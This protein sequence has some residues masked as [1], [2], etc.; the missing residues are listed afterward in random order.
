MARLH[1][2]LATFLR[3]RPQPEIIPDHERNRS[4][5]NPDYHEPAVALLFA[6]LL[7]FLGSAFGVLGGDLW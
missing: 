5:C 3:F 2:L 7:R 1:V 6:T 4:Y